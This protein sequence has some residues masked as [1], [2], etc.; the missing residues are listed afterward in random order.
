MI[1][2]GSTAKQAFFPLFAMLANNVVALTFGIEIQDPFVISVAAVNG[3]LSLFYVAAYFALSKGVERASLQRQL[4]VTYAGFACL[5]GYT[6]TAARGSAELYL[7]LTSN[8]AAVVMFGAPLVDLVRDPPAPRPPGIACAHII[9]LRPRKSVQ[10]A[11]VAKKSVEGMP[12]SVSLM[13]AVCSFTWM[14]YGT[15]IQNPFIYL[16][17]GL[18]F[19]L[20]LVQL[21]L[22]VL[23]PFT[24]GKHPKADTP[25]P[26]GRMKHMGADSP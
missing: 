24:P 8:V 3:L 1:R 12:L 21:S 13:G 14:V 16:P 18:G 4:L 23:Y 2:A 6:S 15:Q 9:Q 5:L 11:V 25:P 22:F 19:A 7:G 20:G 26:P 10:K 17:N